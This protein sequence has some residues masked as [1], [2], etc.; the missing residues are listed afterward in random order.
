MAQC[1]VCKADYTPDPD[2][3][4]N[5]CPRCESSNAGWDEWRGNDLRNVLFY[6]GPSVILMLII[7]TLVTGISIF[8]LLVR[9]GLYA[10]GVGV[11]FLIAT[12]LFSLAVIAFTV[13]ARYRF[14]E[15]MLLGQAREKE[16]DQ[17][18]FGFSPV[19]TLFIAL[20]MALAVATIVVVAVA[21]A[22][23]LFSEDGGLW[24]LDTP[25]PTPTATA[26]AAPTPITTAQPTIVSVFTPTPGPIVT[27]RAQPTA[28]P[29]PSEGPFVVL[30]RAMAGQFRKALPLYVGFLYFFLVVSAMYFLAVQALD[31]YF[32]KLDEKVPPPIFLQ[33]GLLL[34]VVQKEACKY[35]GADSDDITWQDL[36]RTKDAGYKL[37]ARHKYDAK[38]V[39]DP[40]G[41]R[42]QQPMFR[43][44]E[45]EADWWGVLRKIQ[46]SKETHA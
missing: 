44:Y 37:T 21:F 10:N 17:L 13:F 2:Q 6:I 26:S 41:R 31:P 39:D 14:R 34:Q 36:E 45:I 32:R 46:E 27:R 9:P 35:N 15:R 20:L 16:L 19:M 18:G 22:G 29:A 8:F 42:T 25:T 5:P 43:K 33:P 24:P 1:I 40:L 4:E 3:E 23:A 30:L 7:L 12:V 38:R 28:A 11:L